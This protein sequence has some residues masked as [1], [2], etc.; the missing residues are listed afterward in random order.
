MGSEMCIRDRL[1]NAYHDQH[2][3]RVER[4]LWNKAFMSAVEE[5]PMVPFKE[6]MQS[7]T[8]LKNHVKNLMTYGFSV[9]T[10]VNFIQIL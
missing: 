10:E 3:D 2:R 9:V 6:F 8:G 4:V 7:E 5:Q 1:E